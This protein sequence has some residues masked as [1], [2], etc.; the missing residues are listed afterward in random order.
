M[1]FLIELFHECLWNVAST[2]Y[3]KKE[4][5]QTALRAMSTALEERTTLVFGVSV[6]RINEAGASICRS[7]VLFNP[8]VLS[9]VNIRTKSQTRCDSCT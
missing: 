8:F 6:R 1:L 2:N 4:H 5:R 3:H 7:F 9:Y